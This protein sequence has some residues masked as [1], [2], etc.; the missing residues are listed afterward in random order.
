MHGMVL[1]FFATRD[2][3]HVGTLLSVIIASYHAEIVLNE[4]K[5]KRDKALLLCSVVQ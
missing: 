3:H 4:N 1:D 2:Y 5:I